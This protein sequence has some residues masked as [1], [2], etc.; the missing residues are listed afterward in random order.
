VRIPEGLDGTAALAHVF[1]AF[2]DEHER[3]FG[4][5][6]R[7]AQAVEL[8]NLRLQAVGA[9]YHPRIREADGRA[10]GDGTPQ[11][12]R[13]AWFEEGWVD[14][15]VYDRD[16]LPPEARLSGPAIVEEFGSTIVVF[17]GWSARVDGYGNLIMEREA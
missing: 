10:G 9:V 16:R 8:V 3:I 4:F 17:A 11:R 6:Y 7:G 14:T 5:G 13:Q 12:R 15:P 2:H 1:D